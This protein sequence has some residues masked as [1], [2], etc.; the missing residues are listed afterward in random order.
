MHCFHPEFDSKRPTELIIYQQENN[1]PTQINVAQVSDLAT[2]E[3]YNKLVT[4]Q[5]LLAVTLAAVVLRLWVAK[6]RTSIRLTRLALLVEGRVAQ[7]Q[8]VVCVGYGLDSCQLTDSLVRRLV[9]LC[10]EVR[11][12]GTVARRRVCFTLQ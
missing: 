1:R 9:H 2:H 4:E 5:H 10:V 7:V 8:G 3:S 6:E 12:T 11:V